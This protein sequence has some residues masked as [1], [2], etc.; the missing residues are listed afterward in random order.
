M[1]TKSRPKPGN[2][3]AVPT[4][5]N[6]DSDVRAELVSVAKRQDRSMSWVANHLLRERL[7]LGP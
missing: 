1:T 2:L 3:K 4:T 5:L 7:K 6:L